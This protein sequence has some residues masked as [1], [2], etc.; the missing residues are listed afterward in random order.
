MFKD[1]LRLV[2]GRDQRMPWQGARTPQVKNSAGGYAWALDPLG[3]LERFL[4]LGS[5]DGTYYAGRRAKA[6]EHLDVIATAL[7]NHGADAVARIV[8]ISQAGRAPRND[9][10]IFALAV[11]LKLGDDATRAA[12]AAAVPVVCR[13]GTHVFQLA[14]AVDTLGGWGRGTRR[15]FSSW[16]AQDPKRLA[17]QGVKVSKRNGWSHR[18][19]LRKVH[20]RPPSPAHDA[21]YGWLCRGFDGELPYRPVHEALALPWAA[22]QARKAT[23]ADQVVAL[24]R[25]HELPREAL[26]TQ[27]LK[28]PSVWQALLLGGRGM[29]MTAMLRNLGVM[30]GLGLFKHRKTCDFVVERLTDARRLRRARVHPLSILVA[31]NTYK[32]GKGIR[33]SGSWVPHPRVIDALDRAFDLAFATVEPTGRRHLLAVDVSGSMG[34]SQI[35]GMT[36][37]TPRIGAA[38]MALAALRT[39]PESQV[40]AFSHQLVPVGL[41]AAMRLDHVVD[42]LDRIP[43][44]GTDCALPMLWARK[45]KVPVDVFVVYTDSETWAGAAHPAQAL[46][47]YRRAMGIDAKLIVV[48]MV[49]NGFSIADPDDPGMLDVVGFDTATP[50][51]M[52]RFVG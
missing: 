35:A 7:D 15:A 41:S 32:G 36:G 37:V 48:G 1:I 20:A 11:A 10:A 4:V 24:I 52:A 42:T 26:P 14:S 5:A 25:A 21:L 38:A 8:A 34:W 18:D 17:L 22:A 46:R 16:Y 28:K 33:G 27:W 9:Q 43:M 13:T 2:S 40:V 30:T 12:A 6:A 50:A 3:R 19:L 29:P 49:S 47:D 45:R 31:L 23:S 51:L 39:E 44:G